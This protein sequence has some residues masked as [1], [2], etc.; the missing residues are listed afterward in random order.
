M[1]LSANYLAATYMCSL[2]SAASAQYQLF[3]IVQTAGKYEGCMYVQMY[4]YKVYTLI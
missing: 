1:I 4:T 2:C 3:E